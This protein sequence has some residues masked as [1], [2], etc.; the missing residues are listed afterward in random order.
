[1]APGVPL[2]EYGQRH[3]LRRQLSQS[4][5]N[6]AG[7]LLYT[8]TMKTQEAFCV[9][10]DSADTRV[11]RI[12]DTSVDGTCSRCDKPFHATPCQSCGGFRIDGSFGVPGTRFENLPETVKCWD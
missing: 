7:N 9:R 6:I 4:R 1:M 8:R 12:D 11:T 5:V 2:A 3:D 10:C